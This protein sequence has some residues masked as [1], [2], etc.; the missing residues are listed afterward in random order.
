MALLH[1]TALTPTLGVRAVDTRLAVSYRKIK[2]TIGRW[3]NNE[4]CSERA[5]H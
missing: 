2:A 1:Q 5:H 3:Q 4:T